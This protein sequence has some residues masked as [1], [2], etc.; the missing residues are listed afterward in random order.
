MGERVRGSLDRV[1]RDRAPRG[2]AIIES[3][4]VIPLMIVIVLAI[5]Q[6]TQIEQARIMTEFAAFSAARAGIVWNGS[7]TRM[8]DAALVALLPTFGRT[9]SAEALMH[10]WQRQRAADEEFTALPWGTPLPATING[11]PLNGLVRVDAVAP[12]GSD[13]LG[14]I[15]NLRGVHDWKEIDFDSAYTYPEA[16]GLEHRFD[17]FDHPEKQDEGQETLRRASLL[18]I[19]VRHWYELRVPVANWFLFVCWYASHARADR[20][21]EAIGNQ[22]GFPTAHRSEMAL[23]WALSTGQAS[24]GAGSRRRFFIPLSATYTMRMQSN[25]YRKWLM[26]DRGG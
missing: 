14:R 12:E 16:P 13:E 18:T 10:T 9:D 17:T 26:H 4:L 5:L 15:W 2:Q 23:L 24:L 20:P 8:R 6:L 21:A 25:F 1:A 22:R 11:A 19:R 3:V 7:N